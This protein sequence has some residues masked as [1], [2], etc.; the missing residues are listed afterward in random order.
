MDTFYSNIN[1]R[2]KD[3]EKNNT[4]VLNQYILLDKNPNSWRSDPIWNSAYL[5]DV[6]NNAV[7]K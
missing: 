7:K 1:Y 4:D 6:E 2:A 3:L 5:Y